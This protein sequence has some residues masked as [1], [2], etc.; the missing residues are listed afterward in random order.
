MSKFLAVLA[1][2]IAMFPV[3][4]QAY[5]GGD[6][7]TPTKGTCEGLVT[8]E[9]TQDGRSGVGVGECSV[10]QFKKFVLKRC[11]KF[12]VCQIKGTIDHYSGPD[13]PDG[14]DIITDIDSI[15]MLHR[16]AD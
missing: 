10:G 7:I 16:Y 13:Y 11:P 8:V 12:S 14:F 5:S 1:L 9:E 15:K 4:A 2:G 3:L 6:D